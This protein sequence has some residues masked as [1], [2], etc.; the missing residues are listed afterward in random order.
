MHAGD[1]FADAITPF[2]DEASG[3]SVL[4]FGAT[5]EKAAAGIRNVETVIPGHAAVTNWQAFLDYGEFNRLIVE[6]GRASMKAGKT[7]EQ[8]M[9]EF[10]PP[11]K[12]SGYSLNAPFGRGGKGGNFTLL[13]EE[14][15]GAR[16]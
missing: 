9:L 16:P 1:A 8:A 3:G 4:Q 5:L 7:A 12:F 11:A 15:K 14:L 6:H 2:V 10:K 13:Y